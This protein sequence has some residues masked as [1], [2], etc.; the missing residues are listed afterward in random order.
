MKS[1]LLDLTFKIISLK[2]QQLPLNFY[3]S[4]TFI[5]MLHLIHKSQK[6]HLWIWYHVLQGFDLRYRQPVTRGRCACWEGGLV[7]DVAYGSSTSV[8]IHLQRVHFASL[9]VS[10]T[11]CVEWIMIQAGTAGYAF[12]VRAQSHLNH[13]L[14]HKG[15]R[16]RTKQS[17]F[18]LRTTPHFPKVTYKAKPLLVSSATPLV[19]SRL[20]SRISLRGCRQRTQRPTWSSF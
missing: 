1:S 14:S 18:C 5:L 13:W 3:Y 12:H 9:S 7:T 6:H 20:C 15:C 16:I 4:S 11:G 10:E 2:N 17:R 19:C 8:C